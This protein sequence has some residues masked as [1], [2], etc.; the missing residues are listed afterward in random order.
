[1]CHQTACLL[2]GN[3][4]ES[5]VAHQCQ[6][7][8]QEQ[9]QE[10]LYLSVLPFPNGDEEQRVVSQQKLSDEELDKREL[11]RWP[12]CCEVCFRFKFILEC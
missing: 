5:V 2:C 9:A 7:E 11:E 4:E 3:D 1:M 6:M 10:S 8:K 12:T